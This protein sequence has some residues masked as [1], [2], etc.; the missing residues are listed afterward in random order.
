MLWIP[1]LFDSAVQRSARPEHT[2]AA[3][4][5]VSMMIFHFRHGFAGFVFSL[6]W[7]FGLPSHEKISPCERQISFHCLSQGEPVRKPVLSHRNPEFI[8][9]VIPVPQGAVPESP[10]LFFGRAPVL[11]RVFHGSGTAA[12]DQGPGLRPVWTALIAVGFQEVQNVVVHG[13][14]IVARPGDIGHFKV[15]F[16]LAQNIQDGHEG[17]QI[18]AGIAA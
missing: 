14:L 12:A 13:I 7:Y 4:A 1:R 11:S 16:H 10:P 3:G 18:R 2:P 9:P 8:P 15:I 17:S 5:A 6:C